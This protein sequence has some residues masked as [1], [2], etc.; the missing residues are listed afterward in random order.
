MSGP[1]PPPPKREG[2]LLQAPIPKLTGLPQSKSSFAQRQACRYGTTRVEQMPKGYFHHAALRSAFC[3]VFLGWAPKP[4]TVARRRLNACML[5]KLAMCEGLSDWE[6]GSLAN[7]SKLAKLSPRQE[8]VLGRI[9]RQFFG[10]PA[11]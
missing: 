7:V 2:A 9:Y 3:S 4:S 1:A 10:E 5:A 8:M 6:R 11:T